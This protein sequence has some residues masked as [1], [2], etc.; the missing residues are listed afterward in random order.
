MLFE[1]FHIPSQV[2]CSGDKKVMEVRGLS[3]IDISTL[4]NYHKSDLTNLIR[5]WNDF[6]KESNDDIQETI[7]QFTFSL[8]TE[9]PG[10][11]ANLIATCADSRDNVERIARLPISIQLS[12]VDAIVHLTSDDFGGMK[13]MLGKIAEYVVANAPNALKEEVAKAMNQ[14]NGFQSNTHP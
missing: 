11:I 1:D 6:D 9:A 8:L 7:S 14:S 13:A 5:L 4:I 3:F 12:A 2:V 10:I